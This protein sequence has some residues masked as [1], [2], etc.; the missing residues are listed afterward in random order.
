MPL[1]RRIPKLSRFNVPKAR[2]RKRNITEI[3]VGK[4][5]S[6][7]PHSEVNLSTLIEIGIVTQNNGPLKVLGDGELSIPLIVEAAAFTKTARNKIEEA[8]G[9]CEI[10]SY[11]KTSY[12]DHED[13]SYKDKSYF[14]LNWVDKIREKTLKKTSFADE[15]HLITSKKQGVDSHY[16][17]EE[18]LRIIRKIMGNYETSEHPRMIERII[19][20]H[21]CFSSIRRKTSINFPSKCSI[22]KESMLS[23]EMEINVPESIRNLQKK[24][25]EIGFDVEQVRLD[26]YVMAQGFDILEQLK[27]IS[28]KVDEKSKQI[29]FKMIPKKV[30]KQIIHVNF[31]YDAARV[32]HALVETLVEA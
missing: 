21:P 14:D 2:E 3:N 18:E 31:F 28:F 10:S 19:S 27:T 17:S 16:F 29:S 20:S 5:A 13:T 24:F 6:L 12:E 15:T 1:Y 7:P 8:G 30:G 22:N 25:L 26:I 4:L 11:K 23:V 9:I 32:G